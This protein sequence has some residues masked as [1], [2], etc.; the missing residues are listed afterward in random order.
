MKYVLESFVSNGAPEE[1]LYE[2]KPHIGTDILVEVVKNMREKII[3]FGGTFR[4]NTTLTDIEIENN[5]VKTIT[6]NNT[7][8][9]NVD[10]LV[11]AIGH[12]A[13]D[14]FEMLNQKEL[15]LQA[16]PFAVGVR[17]SHPQS[18]IN[19]SQYGE[20]S[21]YLPPASYKLT[22][23]TK[24]GR[25]V[26][27]F[28]MCPGGYVVNASSEEG[29]LAVNGM[30]YSKRDSEN[31]N[32]ALIVTV[33][34]K[35]F[36]DQ[37]LSGLEFQRSLEENAYKVGNKSIPIQQYLDYKNKKESTTIGEVKPIIKGNYNYGDINKIFPDYINESL[38][39]AI[40]NFGTK[41]KDYNRD[42]ALLMGV[43]SRTSSPVKIPRDDNYVSKISGIYPCGEGAGYAGGITSAAIDGVK[44][45][46]AIAKNI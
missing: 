37:P 42:D 24:S 4:Y 39:E 27:S 30:S 25:G 26:Y 36:G 1:I 29:R 15:D 45:A 13:R 46:E 16:K 14:T 2:A 9:E 31:A 18:M 34:P 5:K 10:N 38:V 35:D 22:Y 43:E 33:S 23:Q 12:S 8:K 3:S 6:L 41:I 32:S 44:V 7:E 17:I 11:L 21:K 28:C 19:H 40:E 20:A